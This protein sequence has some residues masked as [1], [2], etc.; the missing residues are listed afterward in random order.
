[1]DTQERALAAIIKRAAEV[2]GRDAST[3]GRGT[4]FGAELGAKS[5]QLVQI[6]TALEDEFE[7]EIP[8]MEFKRRKTFGEAAAFVEQLV[9]G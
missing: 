5:A 4:A 7:V 2:F 6:T 8:Y 3:L 9:E 1:M